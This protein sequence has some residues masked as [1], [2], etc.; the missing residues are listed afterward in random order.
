MLI[1]FFKHGVDVAER[2]S[3]G[4]KEPCFGRILFVK[5]YRYGVVLGV[6]FG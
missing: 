2:I 1:E 5:D 6:H 3:K 4:A